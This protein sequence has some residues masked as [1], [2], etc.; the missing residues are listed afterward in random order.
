[1]QSSLQIPSLSSRRLKMK[2]GLLPKIV[3]R[4]SIHH[5]PP[6]DFKT[7]TFTSDF[8][9]PLTLTRSFANHSYFPSGIHS[10]FDTTALSF[11][12]I[13]LLG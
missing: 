4:Q 7:A 6:F 8:M 11:K 13:I 9:T 1:M 3:H 5:D 10:L 12:D 2:L